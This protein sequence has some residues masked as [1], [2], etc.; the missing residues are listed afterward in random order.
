[1]LSGN[2]LFVSKSK[3]WMPKYEGFINIMHA[4]KTLYRKYG[5]LIQTGNCK[6]V[7]LLQGFSAFIHLGFRITALP[8]LSQDLRSKNN[9]R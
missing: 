1:M 4:V 6:L 9:P 7:Q 3:T 2:R 8:R 5:L